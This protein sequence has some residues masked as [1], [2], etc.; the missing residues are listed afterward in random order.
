V[1]GVYRLLRHRALFAWARY[2]RARANGA[3]RYC[4]R[5]SAPRVTIAC[6]GDRSCEEIA[7]GDNARDQARR[8]ARIPRANES[9]RISI[10]TLP[11]LLGCIFRLLRGQE[12][13]PGGQ[14]TEL[15]HL[16]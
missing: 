9:R 13:A 6:A 7:P 4:L 10:H 14:P 3:P 16:L 5:V 8:R 15:V 2:D 11:L 12:D 1:A